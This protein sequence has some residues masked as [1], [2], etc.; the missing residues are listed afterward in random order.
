MVFLGRAL[1]QMRG[2]K[3][4]APIHSSAGEGDASPVPETAKI[5]VVDDDLDI[6]E[7]LNG[8]IESLGYRTLSFASAAELLAFP[9]R[10]DIDCMIVDVR[11][12]GLDGIELQAQLRKDAR[13]PPIMFMTSYADDATRKRALAGGACCFLG[14][15]VDDKVLVDCLEAALAGRCRASA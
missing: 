7:A 9:K 10:E 12:P 11:M 4:H 8:L 15:P 1:A 5:A 14:K 3:C 2:R 6:R 13:C